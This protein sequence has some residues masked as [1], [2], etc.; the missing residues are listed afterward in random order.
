MKTV[1]IAQDNID[2]RWTMKYAFLQKGYTVLETG[3]GNDVLEM[4]RTLRPD[5][6]I[7]DTQLQGMGGVEILSHLKAN[8]DSRDIPVLMLG[9][10][11]LNKVVLHTVKRQVEAY[12]DKASLSLFSLLYTAHKVMEKTSVHPIPALRLDWEP[13]Y[14][15]V[16]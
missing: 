13:R 3:K 5:L 11:G 16:A 7:L 4:V 12:F 1:L 14:A 15:T 10:S 8:P 9:F 6:I 2:T